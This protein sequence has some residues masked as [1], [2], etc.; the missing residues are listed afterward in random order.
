LSRILETAS[1]V[2]EKQAAYD[3]SVESF[4]KAAAVVARPAASYGRQTSILDGPGEE[5]RA[6]GMPDPLQAL[7]TYSLLQKTLGD[8]AGKLSPPN[9]EARVNS[10]LSSLN[11]PSHESKLR[12]INSQSMLHDLM[13]N[14]EVISG[15]NPN[16]VSDA[17]NDIVQISP[18]VG[19]Q[20]MLMQTL[21]RHRLTQGQLDAFEQDKLLSFEDALRRQNTP[22]GGAR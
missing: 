19:D 14:D 18:S 4:S 6:F 12:S 7:G 9:D 20:R 10:V 5:K 13:S 16:E 1:L 21:L 3:Q 11:D 17:Y 15:Y 22:M 8:T 2:A